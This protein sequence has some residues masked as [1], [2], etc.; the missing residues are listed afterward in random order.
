MPVWPR[1]EAVLLQNGVASQRIG[2]RL[3]VPTP[4][5]AGG[6]EVQFRSAPARP[7]VDGYVVVSDCRSRLALII[8][9]LPLRS[10]DFRVIDRMVSLECPHWIRGCQ[11]VTSRR[12]IYVYRLLAID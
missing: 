4:P 1:L 2:S 7:E 3:V 8:N 10:G 5:S 11:E 6:C 12:D 9:R